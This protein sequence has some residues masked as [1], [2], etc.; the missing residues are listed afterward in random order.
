MAI[1]A[2]MIEGT[3]LSEFARRFPDRLFDV[4]IAEQFAVTFAAGMAKAGYKPVAAIYSTFLMRAYD[5]VYHDVCLQDLPVVFCIDR[6]GLVGK[7]GP[8]HHGNYDFSYLR[9]LPNMVIMTPMNEGELRKM[10][11]TALT[12]NHPVAIRY[13][14]DYGEGVKVNGRIGMIKVGKGEQ[15]REGGDAT[16]FAVGSMVYPALRLAEELSQKDWELGVVNAR[17]VKP[18]DRELIFECSQPGSRIITMEEN[19]LQGGFGSAVM[20]ALEE[21]GV[22]NHISLLRIGLPDEIVPH[23]SREELLRH[24]GLDHEGLKKR[25]LG[26]LKR[27]ES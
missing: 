10:L 5:Q 25:I 22:N 2:A 26:F 8:T 11:R 20:E 1:T 14:R 18:L 21:T 27:R 17:F 19:V 4:G 9:H 12:I 15:L 3:G 16:I 24:C 23:G 6:S 13:P 7:D